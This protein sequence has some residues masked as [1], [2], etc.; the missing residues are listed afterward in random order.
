LRQDA[1]QEGFSKA[2][3]VSRAISKSSK[4]YGNS[5]WDLLDAYKSDSTVLLSIDKET[6]PDSLQA[7][8]QEEIETLVLQKAK[9]RTEIQNKIAENAVKRTAYIAQNQD[10]TST[11]T[12]GDRMIK[13]IQ[14]EAEKN[15]FVFN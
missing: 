13:T 1:N 12:L 10:T 14:K 11:Q 4:L 8:E 7:L 5:H 9:E 15:G 6:L 3:G 2:N